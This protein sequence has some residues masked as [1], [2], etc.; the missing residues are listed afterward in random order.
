MPNEW[1]WEG[2][3]VKI[4]V[5]HLE[6][7]DWVI[8]RTADTE[9]REAGVDIIARKDNVLLLIEVKGYPS[10]LYQRGEHKGKQKRTSPSTQAKHWYSGV[11]LSAILRQAENSNAVVAIALPDFPVFSKLVHRTRQALDKLGIKVY[12]VEENGV[13]KPGR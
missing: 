9:S 12:L 2:N 6:K 1:Y 8:E 13:V 7:E 10:K 3:V 4:V 5:A 11:F